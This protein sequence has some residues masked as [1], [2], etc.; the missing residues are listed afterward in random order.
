MIILIYKWSWNNNNNAY[1]NYFCIIRNLYSHCG[2]F[3][4]IYEEWCAT[5]G[6]NIIS[7]HHCTNF[8]ILIWAW[9]TDGSSVKS[10]WKYLIVKKIFRSILR[11]WKLM[12]YCKKNWDSKPAAFCKN[13]S[14]PNVRTV[15]CSNVPCR[16]HH[17]NMLWKW[18][19]LTGPRSFIPTWHFNGHT[20]LVQKD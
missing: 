9:W 8:L 14:V 5:T 11:S 16:R 4:H 13:S 17:S 20:V 6:L 10:F 3:S 12:N 7:K 19:P 18:H 1:H 2:L 15:Q